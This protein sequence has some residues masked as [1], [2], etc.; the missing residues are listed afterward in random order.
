[1]EGP[2]EFSVLGASTEHGTGRFYLSG[3]SQSPKPPSFR[4]CP[5]NLF[6]SAASLVDEICSGLRLAYP[7]GEGSAAILHSMAPKSRRVSPR[8]RSLPTAASNSGR[9]SPASR[10][11]SPTAAASW[12]A[13]SSQSSSAMP[14]VA[15][16]SPSYGR[17]RSATGALRWTGTGG[18]SAASSSPPLCLP[19]SSPRRPPPSLACCR[20]APPPGCPSLGS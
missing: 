20:T 5:Q 6:P 17:S 3:K 10:R 18:S 13:T 9:A 7:A 12:S 16:D 8:R 4:P 14:T 19:W 1:M 15:R 2:V 11:S